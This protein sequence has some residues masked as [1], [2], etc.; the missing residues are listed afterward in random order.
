ML[1]TCSAPWYE[2]R[3]RMQRRRAVVILRVHIRRVAR[4][5]PLQ[6]TQP[7]VVAVVVTV[8]A[9]RRAVTAIRCA[10]TGATAAASLVLCLLDGVLQSHCHV[11]V[12]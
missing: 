3:R 2:Q 12:P 7:I 10:A 4:E 6:L 11:Q 1:R 9:I 5:Q 8:A